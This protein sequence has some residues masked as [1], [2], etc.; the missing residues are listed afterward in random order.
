MEASFRYHEV[1]RL[2][3]LGPED[4][5]VPAEGDHK[6]LDVAYLRMAVVH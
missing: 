1:G 5:D 4:T 6:C 3:N 2:H